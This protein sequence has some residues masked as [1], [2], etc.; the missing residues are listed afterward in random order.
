[1]ASASDI[2][3]KIRSVKNMEKVTGA[4][5]MVAAAKLRRA[6]QSIRALRPYAV[7]MG[8][9]MRQ[10]ALRVPTEEGAAPHPL[11][12]VFDP[13]SRVL[14]LVLTSD[15]GLC[16]GFNTNTLRMAEQLIARER[17][18]Y[19][20]LEVA[21]I[22]RRAEEHFRKRKV[23]S[24]RNF[25]G[26]F[27]DLTFRR[28]QE[29]AEGLSKEYVESDLDAVFVVYNE[30]KS[31]ISQVLQ[32]EQVLPVRQEALPEGQF[33]SEY[34]WEK[35]PKSVLD[36]LVPRYVAIGIWRALLDSWASEQGARMSA[37]DNASKNAR[38]LVD[39]LTLQYN[40]ARQAG[41]TKELMD[42]IGGAEAL[43]G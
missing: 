5:K 40:R 29:I 1:M 10:V 9:L 15:R 26:V 4:M 31:A 42:I 13:P 41:I 32:I 37:M 27:E 25:K 36:E 6:E 28:A 7:E 11:L 22:G 8:A 35:D 17:P 34:I 23:A 14:V 2:R 30:F 3:K 18:K 19:Q 12:Q 16:G 21:T 38:E 20:T 33:A 39:D 43:Q 24:V